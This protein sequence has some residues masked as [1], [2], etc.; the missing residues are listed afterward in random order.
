[1]PEGLDTINLKG[2]QKVILPE[3]SRH[4]GHLIDGISPIIACVGSQEDFEKAE[5]LDSLHKHFNKKSGTAVHNVFY[6]ALPSYFRRKNFSSAGYQTYV[7]SIIDDRDKFSKDLFDC[8]GLIV[9]GIDKKT[10]KM[11]LS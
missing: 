11:F 5:Q 10:K 3:T 8:T 9:T 4:L 1:M 6:D 7:I 2:D